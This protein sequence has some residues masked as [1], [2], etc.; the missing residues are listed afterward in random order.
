MRQIGTVQNE[1]D[2]TRLT[3]YLLTLGITTRVLHGA[4]GWDLWVHQEDK[5]PVARTELEAFLKDPE[6]P[7]YTGHS[8]T[9]RTLRKQTEREQREHLRQSFDVRYFWGA[10]DLQRC[11]LTFLLIGLSVVVAV[12]SQLGVRESVL[13][14]LYI[15]SF[16]ILRADAVSTENP[17]PGILVEKGGVVILSNLPADL[18]RGEVWRLVSPIFI[19][20]GLI[21]LLFNMSFL[22]YIGGEIEVRCKTPTL[23]ALVLVSAV[24]SNLG[25]Y[26]YSGSPLFGGMSGVDLA[27]FGFVWMKGQY[28]P[29]LGLSLSSGTIMFVVAYLAVT[30]G[31]NVSL[32]AN[33]AHLVGLCVGVLAGVGPHLL[34]YR[35]EADE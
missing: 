8:S 33:A 18:M 24:A 35:G 34:P 3:D 23:L 14:P 28:E 21:H 20:F 26:L 10:H 9:A 1:A 27:L 22:Y 4:D 25:Q 15:A 6:D 13:K 2:A 31:A 29:E 17:P 5:V 19:H 16:Q 32:I 7:R 30:I 12:I 11:P